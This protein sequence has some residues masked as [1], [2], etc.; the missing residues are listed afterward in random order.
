MNVGAIDSGRI[1]AM[2]AQL[3][4]AATKPA[5]AA[6]CADRRGR[7]AGGQG[8][9]LGRAEKLAR[10]GQQQPDQGRRDGQGLRLGRRQG[11]PVGR[12]DL[13]AEGQHRL[14]GHGPGAQQ[15]GVGVPRNHEHAG[16]IGSAGQRQL[17]P[18]SA[19]LLRP[20]VAA[21]D[22]PSQ[23][24]AACENKYLHLHAFRGCGA[25]ASV[26]TAPSKDSI[27]TPVSR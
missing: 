6:I 1:E 15:D 20:L 11:Q 9:L 24:P 23:R 14:S 2:I 18:G 22:P 21:G 3:K 10:T 4:A 27:Y 13:D 12:D 5:G 8:Q 7:S 26:Q 17:D 19:D 25:L 16:V